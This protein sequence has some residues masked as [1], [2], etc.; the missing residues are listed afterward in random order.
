[1]P[2]SQPLI[3]TTPVPP[4]RI[5]A[6][7][8]TPE[9]TVPTPGRIDLQLPSEMPRDDDWLFALCQANRALRIERTSQGDLE[10]M[11]PTGAETGARN[12]ELNRH[13]GN[14]AAADGRGRVF[15][16]STGFLLPN[17]AMR[18]PDLAWVQRV[19]LAELS[20]PQKRQFL[21]LAPDALIELASP[22]DAP[23]TL[24]AKMREWR[25]NGVRLGWLILPEQRQVWRYTPE[26]EPVCLDHPAE[27]RDEDLLPGLAVPLGGIWET[28]L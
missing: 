20:A 10:I 2:S 25:D 1:M 13:V 22:S 7:T 6:G 21:P 9:A 11:S 3:S 15:D 8:M 27:L 24:H 19:R 14:W 28:G 12:S 4:P 18:S 16:S 23:E 17:G 5:A 26:A